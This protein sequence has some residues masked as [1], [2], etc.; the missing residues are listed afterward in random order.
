MKVSMPLSY[1]GGFKESAAQAVALEKAGL[2]IG[3][4]R[5]GLRLRRRQPH[6]LPGGGHRDRRDR[7]GHPPH[8][9]A[10]PHA[11][12]HDRGR[13]RRPV[14]R[15]VR[16]RARRLGPAGDRGVPRRAVR[17]S[18]SPAPARSSRSAARCGPASGSTYEGKAYTLPLPPE[19]GTGLGKPLKLITRP[20]RERIPIYVA[21]ARAEERAHDRR[22]GRRLAAAVLPAREGRRRVGRRPGRGCG[23]PVGRPGPAGDRGRRP[24]G[25]RRRRRRACATS[26]GR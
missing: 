2:D 17:R 23:R 25:G 7:G 15:P 22:G 26:P 1:A 3:V 4:G 14:R 10:H 19:Q 18:R 5:R 24:A 9:H 6:G 13:R 20:V 11:A 8:L 21:A 12:R 16:P